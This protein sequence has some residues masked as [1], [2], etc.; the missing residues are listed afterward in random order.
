MYR[1]TTDDIEPLTQELIERGGE[2]SPDG[3]PTFIDDEL[4]RLGLDREALLMLTGGDPGVAASIHLGLLI[5][6]YQRNRVEV[7]A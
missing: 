2:P 1:F 6:E 4:D 5:A 3:S 7:P